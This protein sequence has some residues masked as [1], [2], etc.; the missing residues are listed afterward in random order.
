MA[1]GI[2]LGLF[3]AWFMSKIL[4]TFIIFCSPFALPFVGIAALLAFIRVKKNDTIITLDDY[5]S[6]KIL[7]KQ[8]PR[9]YL[10]YRENIE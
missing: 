4:H 9:H 5:I 7:F 10:K 2:G 3:A 1:I 6:R 8:R